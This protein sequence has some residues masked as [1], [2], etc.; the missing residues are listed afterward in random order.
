[1]E[2]DILNQ[3]KHEFT[4]MLILSM[5]QQMNQSGFEKED[6]AKA[7]IDIF[8]SEFDIMTIENKSGLHFK[9]LKEEPNEFRRYHN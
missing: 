7:L 8:Q 6:I 3:V 1:M 5:L 4:K 9:F 2:Q